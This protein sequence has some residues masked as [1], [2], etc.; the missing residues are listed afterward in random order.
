MA[1][2]HDTASPVSDVAAPPEF[3]ASNRFCPSH[4]FHATPKPAVQFDMPDA[5]H[6]PFQGTGR[7]TAHW[8]ETAFLLG[9]IGC[10]LLSV[11]I[12]TSHLIQA[13]NQ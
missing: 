8:R 9:A 6:H 2:P 13:A 11:L 12:A 1:R 10:G 4:R 5:M 3:A 7:K